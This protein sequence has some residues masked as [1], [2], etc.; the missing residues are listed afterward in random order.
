MVQGSEGGMVGM[1]GSLRMAGSTVNGWQGGVASVNYQEYVP[2]VWVGKKSANCL[3]GP[4]G[5]LGPSRKVLPKVS[6]PTAEINL[7]ELTPRLQTQAAQEATTHPQDRSICMYMCR[8]AREF[9]G[10]RGRCEMSWGA[11]DY[12]GG[13]G[14]YSDF[15]I[16]SYLGFRSCT[17]DGGYIH[18]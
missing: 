15:K 3:D 10:E 2:A 17:R 11:V 14:K 7:Q 13:G 5:R 4:P 6:R 9:S 16:V 18:I 1:V 8:P 12:R